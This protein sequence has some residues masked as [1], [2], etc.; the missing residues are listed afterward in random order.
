MTSRRRN[1]FVVG[2]GMTKV[3]EIATLD[4]DYAHTEDYLFRHYRNLFMYYGRPLLRNESVRPLYF[5]DSFFFF[6]S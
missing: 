6:S 5:T 3:R 4:C 2:V 1:V